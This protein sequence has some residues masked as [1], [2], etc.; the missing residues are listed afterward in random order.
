MTFNESLIDH[1]QCIRLVHDLIANTTVLAL[2][3]RFF[4]QKICLPNY[5]LLQITLKLNC[6]SLFL[7]LHQGREE[8]V[9]KTIP[10]M[11]YMAER[12]NDQL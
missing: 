4:F 5:V 2:K 3:C 9:G 8:K 1:S 11:C 10:Y 6:F 7:G 12:T